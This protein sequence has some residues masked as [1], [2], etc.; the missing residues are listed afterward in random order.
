MKT[1]VKTVPCLKI[2]VPFTMNGVTRPASKTIRRARVAAEFYAAHLN[3]EWWNSYSQMAPV[4]Q[5]R[6][7][8]MDARYDRLYRR[9]LQVFKQYLP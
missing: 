7:V 3:R 6:Y 2:T 1:T 4:G 9:A 8:Q 5:G